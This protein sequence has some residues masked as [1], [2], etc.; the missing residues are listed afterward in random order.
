[1][2]ECVCNIYIY[3]HTHTFFSHFQL[4]CAFIVIMFN[5]KNVNKKKLNKQTHNYITYILN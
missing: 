2:S 5:V 3:I 4:L 1:M